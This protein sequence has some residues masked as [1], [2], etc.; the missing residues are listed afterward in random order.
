MRARTKRRITEVR[1]SASREGAV[2]GA[3]EKQELACAV[4]HEDVQEPIAIQITQSGSRHVPNVDAVKR[5]TWSTESLE[6]PIVALE[7]K[8]RT[9]SIIHANEGVELPIAVYITQGW[10]CA[11]AKVNA[12]KRILTSRNSL[13]ATLRVQLQV[14]ERTIFISD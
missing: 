8:D 1:G 4:R 3:L 13:K 5:R 7:E 11:V 6:A 12:V 9:I 2:G 10:I 14:P